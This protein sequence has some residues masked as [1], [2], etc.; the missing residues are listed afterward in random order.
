MSHAG[1]EAA[2]PRS[3]DD[4]PAASRVSAARPPCNRVHYG[5]SARHHNDKGTISVPADARTG[6]RTVPCPGPSQVCYVFNENN[7]EKLP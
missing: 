4:R 5:V 6:T 2:G 7:K 1:R 3:R